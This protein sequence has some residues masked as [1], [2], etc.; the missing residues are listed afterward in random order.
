MWQ[1]FEFSKYYVIFYSFSVAALVGCL[2]F[3]PCKRIK[4]SW[5]LT[6]HL[7]VHIWLSRKTLLIGFKTFTNFLT[8]HSMATAILKKKLGVGDKYHHSIKVHTKEA[9]NQHQLKS[10]LSEFTSLNFKRK[11]PRIFCSVFYVL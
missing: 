1:I 5:I 4:N 10:P 2:R 9:Q 8:Q 7:T 6:E 11:I 3:V